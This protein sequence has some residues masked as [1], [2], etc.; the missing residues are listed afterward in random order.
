MSWHDEWLMKE[1]TNKDKYSEYIQ[2]VDK[3]NFKCTWCGVTNKYIRNGLGALR[4]HSQTLSHKLKADGRK[5]RIPGQRS[6][7][8]SSAADQLNNERPPVVIPVLSAPVTLDNTPL[9]LHDKVL[10][11]KIALVLKGVESQWS[12][13]SYENLLEVL[14]KVDPDSQIIQKMT[15]S[16]SKV[17]YMVS[18]G[19]GPY[20]KKQLVE[21][22][23]QSGLY[24][25]G[26]D[27]SSFKQGAAGLSTH[28]DLH[29]RFWSVRFNRVIDSIFDLHVL[30]KEPATVQ[31]SKV[32]ESLAKA[33]LS[34][35]KLVSLSRDNPTVMKATARLLKEAAEAAGNPK[36]FDLSCLLHPVHTSSKELTK[37]LQ[38]DITSLLAALHSFFS[39][40]SS[41]R[42]DV[43]T[44]RQELQ[45]M[46]GENFREPIATFFLRHVETRWL[47]IGPVIDRVI[48]L[49]TST[50]KYFLEF[51]PESRLS[52][53][54]KALETD[55]YKSIA[56]VLSEE[57]EQANLARLKF[58]SLLASLCKP[59]LLKLQAERPLVYEL[60]SK[61][62]G[63]FSS[64]SATI[65]K[66][67]QVP[68]DG[69]GVLKVDL[70]S[71]DILLEPNR[72]F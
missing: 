66:P 5:N 1:D 52:N 6:L 16:P 4:Q 20:F 13:Q 64:I 18:M 21:D 2:K 30:G 23:R 46:L 62:G 71:K 56:A 33:E 48:S 44:I 65:M 47:E 17:S 58:V 63:L 29:L 11:A 72:Y 54:K 22:V 57:T 9:S 19:L 49:W 45:D 69:K 68:Q 50:R 37:S 15:L 31:S 8:S 10:K 61:M 60:Y 36:L 25:I 53:N 43:I 39:M 42:E 70:K 24:V 40:S 3:E 59:F 51:L 28:L 67:S 34:L 35:T 41:R 26:M 12:Y 55:R 32:Q 7:V 27:G 38:L 14:R